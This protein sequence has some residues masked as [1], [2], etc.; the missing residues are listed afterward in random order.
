MTNDGPRIVFASFRPADG[1]EGDVEKVLRGMV[2]PS[3][4]EPGCE[5]Y[6][7]YRSDR[8]YHLFE[9][10]HNQEALDAHRATDHYQHYRAA[11]GDLLAEPIDVVVL[12]EVDAG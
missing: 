8:G 4:A 7:L 12:T 5:V 1:H 11:I 10:Y 6:D 3:R 2:E 9:R